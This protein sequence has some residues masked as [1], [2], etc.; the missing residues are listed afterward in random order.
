MATALLFL[1]PSAIGIIS[2]ATPGIGA[3]GWALVVVC[4]LAIFACMELMEWSAFGVDPNPM[5][6]RMRS[7]IG[8]R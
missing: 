6:T 2:F 7:I 1:L 8:K 3:G 4:Y 5:P